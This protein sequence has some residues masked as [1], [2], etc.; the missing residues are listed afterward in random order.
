MLRLSVS[1]SRSGFY[2]K[3]KYIA[4]TTV[5]RERAFNRAQRPRTR[6]IECNTRRRGKRGTDG[7]A[8]GGRTGFPKGWEEMACG[9]I[10]TSFSSPGGNLNDCSL[11]RKER[12]VRERERAK[13][14]GTFLPNI[15]L[16]EST[17]LRSRLTP[18]GKAFSFS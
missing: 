15:S 6:L 8:M 2:A 5:G 13:F 16:Y 18:N 7:A 1:N 12:R 4:P 10:S 11:A 9:L 14:G 3:A 17:F